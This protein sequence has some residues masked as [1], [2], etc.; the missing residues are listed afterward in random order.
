MVNNGPLAFVTGTIK[1]EFRDGG[2][3]FAGN[4]MIGRVEQLR[5]ET[6]LRWFGTYHGRSDITW[7]PTELATQEALV[8]KAR[9]AL[10]GET[11]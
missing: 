5:E 8:E 10:M 1:L 2:R 11:A 9:E 4:V 7:H 6:W 3:L